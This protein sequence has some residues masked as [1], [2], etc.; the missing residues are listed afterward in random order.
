MLGIRQYRGVAIDLFQGQLNE[1][2]CDGWVTFSSEYESDDDPPKIGISSSDVFPT[3]KVLMAPIP[4]TDESTFVRLVHAILNIA[5]QQ[6]LA[7]IAIAVE[8]L[9]IQESTMM[10]A[11]KSHLDCQSNTPLLRRVTIVVDTK[12]RYE[13]FQK[14]LFSVFP[15]S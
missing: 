8:G 5:K 3:L 9:A 6:T 15:E 2:Y 1:F 14:A 4:S 12:G 7:H 11:L 10:T 13:V